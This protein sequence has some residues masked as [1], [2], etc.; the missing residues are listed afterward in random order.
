[1]R[2]VGVIEATKEPSYVRDPPYSVET[3]YLP[4][5][6]EHPF[7]LALYVRA[8]ESAAVAP[9][10][11]DVVRQIDARVPILQLES[12]AQANERFLIAEN[13]LARA[14]AILGLI[15]LFLA[16]CGLYGVLSYIVTLRSREI[17]VRLALGAKPRAMVRMVLSQAMT[18]AV[19]GTI[20]GGAGAIAVGRVIQSEV[21]TPGG[22][23][24]AAIVWPAA[25][26]IAVMLA[27]SAI[28]AA[29]AGRVNLLQLL[30][31]N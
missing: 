25:V 10:I 8:H 15:A 27:A 2:V 1:M 16:T 6:L 12:L 18:T 23:N 14:T 4:V 29:R 7:A 13:T 20:I 17:A 30:K 9:L 28:P 24:P 11:R 21:Y 19:V 5:P 3:I 31:E 22:L 26:L